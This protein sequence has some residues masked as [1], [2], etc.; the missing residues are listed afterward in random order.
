MD[1][2]FKNAG[3]DTKASDPY[4]NT[5][6]TSKSHGNGRRF[7]DGLSEQRLV[8]SAGSQGNRENNG[9]PKNSLVGISEQRLVERAGSQGNRENNGGPKNSLIG[10]SEQKTVDSAELQGNM[11]CNGGLKDYDVTH[12]Q[13][14]G[15]TCTDASYHRQG[16]RQG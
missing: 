9:G 12:V 15:D 5:E 8:D 13:K 1:Y 3:I 10:L 14:N 11:R 2:A 4:T 7:L 16:C 6:E